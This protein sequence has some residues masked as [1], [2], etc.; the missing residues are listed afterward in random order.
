[1]RE[2]GRPQQPLVWTVIGVEHPGFM[3]H[4]SIENPSV[5]GALHRT[6]GV[7][8]GA[9]SST[10]GDGSTVHDFPGAPR[11]G[12]VLGGVPEARNRVT[13]V[14][15]EKARDL[16]RQAGH[17]VPKQKMAVWCRHPGKP[18]RLLPITPD[19]VLIGKRIA[20]EIDPCG[21]VTG[22]HGSTHRGKEAED[23]LRNELLADVGW[24]VLRLRLGAEEGMSIGGRDVVCE[25]STMTAN[26]VEAFSEALDDAINGRPPQVRFVPKKASASPRK[27]PTRRSSVFRLGEYR[28]GDQ[29]QIFSW[30][31]NPDTAEKV[32]LRLALNGKYLYTHAKP[33]AF[34]AE[35]GLNEVPRKEWKARIEA[36]LPTLPTLEPEV[37]PKYPWGDVMLVGAD[38]DVDAVAV[39][40]QCDWKCDIDRDVH[41]FTAHCDRLAVATDEA[42]LDDDGVPVVVLH[43]AARALGYRFALLER[44]RGH[45]G[46][47]QRLTL[48]RLPPE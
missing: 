22:H 18:G 26:V 31:P 29:A 10:V 16:M 46:D 37:K 48:T 23:Q 35:V 7:S 43:P 14:V 25:P 44:L 17:R 47:Y 20:I 1:M 9:E 15:E 6:F 3:N 34:L 38:G 42:L 33:P 19:I 45:R 41:T 8:Q 21:V 36:F 40:Q 5:E 13:S 39:V 4:S 30:M 11:T 32:H 2:V 27:P 12:A 28:Y 24:T